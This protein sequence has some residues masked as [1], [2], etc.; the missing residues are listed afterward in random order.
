[1]IYVKEL[2][3]ETT[4]TQTC[5]CV[6]CP[7]ESR[8]LSLSLEELTQCGGYYGILICMEISI[9][10]KGNLNRKSTN[11]C[12]TRSLLRPTL[13]HAG[14]REIGGRHIGRTGGAMWVPLFIVE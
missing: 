8:I 11:S 5:R 6:I 7:P 10:V 4:H 9:S 3:V 14:H 2:E 12:K 13:S 1:M